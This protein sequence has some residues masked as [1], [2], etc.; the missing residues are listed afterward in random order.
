MRGGGVKAPRLPAERGGRGG[1]G[2]DCG[3]QGKYGLDP[4]ADKERSDAIGGDIAEAHGEAVNSSKRFSR[5]VN[6]SFC[7][8]AGIEPGGAGRR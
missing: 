3:Y 8:S 6:L 1:N 5:M 7:G 2:G 4:L